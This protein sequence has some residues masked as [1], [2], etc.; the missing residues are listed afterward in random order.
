MKNNTVFN[1]LWPYFYQYRRVVFISLVFACLGEA[2]SRCGAWFGSRLIGLISADPA[3]RYSILGIAVIYILLYAFL[4]GLRGLTVNYA[5]KIDGTFLPSIQALAYKDLFTIAHKHSPDFFEQEM[6]GNI[7]GKIENTVSIIERFYYKVVWGFFNPAAVLIISLISVGLVNLQ[8]SGILFLLTLTYVYL[9]Y[10]S[11]RFIMPYSKE[12]AS[13]NA[14]ANGDLIDSL[15][16]AEAVKSFG[17]RFFENRWYFAKLHKVAQ[18]ERRELIAGAWIYIFQSSMRS[19]IQIVLCIIPLWFW[20]KEKLSLADYVFVQS[21][22]ISLV[23]VFN[24]MI[25][26]FLEAFSLYSI[27]NDGLNLILK[28]I[29]VKDKPQAAKLNITAANIIFDNVTFAYPE[30]AP[31]FKDFSL[32]IKPK[33]KIGLV[34]CSGSGKS[35]LIKLLGRYYDI[36][37]GS[38]RIDGQNIVDITQNSLHKNIALIPQE[39]NLFNRTIMENIRYGN[40]GAT[41]E[42]VYEAARRAYCHDFITELPNGYQSRVGE[43]GVMLSGG[44]RQRIAIARAILK[45]APILIL[46]EATSALDS[47]SE[48]YI[49][50]SLAELME[51]RTVI[52]VAHRLSTLKKMDKIIVLDNGRIA[53]EGTHNTLI[54]KKGIYSRFYKMQTGSFKK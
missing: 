15:I 40:L 48:L 7:S 33:T 53:E 45:N 20:Y 11:S 49:R 10:R 18:A 13:L 28:P 50:N 19:L 29:T 5:V 26:I 17:R 32:N 27:L 31:V 44:E 1:F 51:G 23:Y 46:D 12:F 21:V 16:N 3:D 39:P 36:D 37:S 6:S 54:R 35:T 34:G 14:A 42:E 41:D 25:N 38:I 47:E 9:M 4:T 43:R 8:L 52:A 30:L 2:F 22:V 24:S